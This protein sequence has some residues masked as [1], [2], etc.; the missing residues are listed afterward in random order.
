[1]RLLTYVTLLGC[2]GCSK[3]QTKIATVEDKHQD[4]VIQHSI[5]RIVE[6]E[7]IIDSLELH[8][9]YAGLIDVQLLNPIICVRLKYSTDTNFLSQNIYGNLQKAYLEENTAKKLAI[10]QI[11]LS[12]THPALRLLIW[13]AARPVSCQQKMWDALEMPSY[14]KGRYVSNPKNHSLHNYGCAVDVT[15]IDSFGEKLDMGTG[16]DQFDSLA[17]PR[18]EQYLVVNKRLTIEQIS[19]RVILR[20]T[21]R[22]AG[23]SGI[24]SEWWHFNG[25]SRSFAKTNYQVIR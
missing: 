19:N 23:F 15:L 18:H 13:D 17:E 20:N 8:M 14:E 7:E 21:M 12:K 10:A 5:P 1:M 3:E 16:F 4:S 25:C 22:N 24:Q 9:M 11:R 2:F 6:E